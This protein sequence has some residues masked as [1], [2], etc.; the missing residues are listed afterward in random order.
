MTLTRQQ[1]TL[2]VILT[3]V[4]G[5]NWPIMKM[6]VTCYPPPPLRS[7]RRLLGLPFL[8]PVLYAGTVTLVVPPPQW[9]VAAAPALPELSLEALAVHRG[10]PDPGLLMPYTQ[11]P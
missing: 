7:L 8:A 4:W 2:L 3:L 10:H 9:P 5:L 11:T 6:G 1:T